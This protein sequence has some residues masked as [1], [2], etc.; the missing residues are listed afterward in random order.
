MTKKKRLAVLSAAGL[1]L[2]CG[3]T[4]VACDKDNTDLKN[5]SHTE[6]FTE[7]S[8]NA[9]SIYQEAKLATLN[10]CEK[11]D[12]AFALDSASFKTVCEAEDFDGFL[13][14]TGITETECENYNILADS[15]YNIYISEN[16]EF[17]DE[18]IEPCIECT[19][20]PLTKLYTI[21]S[22]AKAVGGL[23]S[24]VSGLSD[25]E[26]T[27]GI[28]GSNEI[29]NKIKNIKLRYLCILLYILIDLL[30]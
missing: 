19:N 13:E 2:A 30:P 10:I 9:N 1:F 25:S 18:A 5:V 27:V 21:T 11:I 4:F 20:N 12:A 23:T 26:I 28:S 6:T 3:V 17:N 29:C 8:A 14:L 15:V 16:P 24:V 7:K 22:K